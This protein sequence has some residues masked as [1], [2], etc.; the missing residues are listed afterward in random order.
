MENN[1]YTEETR[2]LTTR[3]LVPAKYIKS[4]DNIFYLTNSKELKISSGVT[5]KAVS[6]EV[7][8]IIKAKKNRVVTC[9]EPFFLPEMIGPYGRSV[10]SKSLICSI[11]SLNKL[12]NFNQANYKK[13]DIDHKEYNITNLD[14]LCL[15]Y[16]VN[17]FF[18][19]DEN[20]GY[21]QRN[22]IPNKSLFLTLNKIFNITG[23]FIPVNSKK[24]KKYF[25][26]NSLF[27]R[28][29]NDIKLLKEYFK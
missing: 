11:N 17:N 24:K 6:S 13:L 12:D 1:F 5:V 29:E 18:V 20:L 7:T 21:T 15:Y 10:S 23:V 4:S 28:S 14:Y 26:S 16:F 9:N 8:R 27:K 3:G 25:T 22:F 19:Y 2:Y